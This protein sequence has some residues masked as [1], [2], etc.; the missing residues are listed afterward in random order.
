[1]QTTAVHH[2]T[3]ALL[4]NPVRDYAWGSRTAIPE[5]LGVA[6]TGVPAAE[7]W[8]G[9]HPGAPSRVCD[10]R[11][12]TL[13]AR[14]E[15]AP[16]A[17]LGADVVAR[18]G[19]RLP[20]LL[21]VIAAAAP[22]SLQ[23]HPNATQAAEGYAQENAR[24]MR[25]TAPDRNYRDPHHKPELLCALTP[26]DALCG[27]RPANDT[28]R[29]LDELLRVA[30]AAG[31]GTPAGRAVPALRPYV[32][33]LR[34]RPNQHGLREVVTGLLTLPMHKRAPLVGAVAVAAELA[35]ATSGEF[36]AELRTA[37]DLSGAYPGDVGV[38]IALLLNLLRLRPG[39][40]IF[41]PAGRMHA[42]LRGTGVEIMA[43]SDNV[44]RGGLT[45]KHVDVAELL[46]IL[47]LTDAP[48]PIPEPHRV[49]PVEEVY[50]TPAP[51][52][53][54]SRLQLDGSAPVTLAAAGPQI[55]LATEGE[56][57]VAG[58]GDPVHLARGRSAWVP[59]GVAI[60]LTGASTAFR[61]T[62]NLA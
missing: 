11:H 46:R 32:G 51:E 25:L 28:I 44:L 19:P 50:D 14:I 33:A 23:A 27:F 9:A 35:A 29:L 31:E 58:A 53:R 56:L 47:D 24:D 62:T 49:G 8:M 6:P 16:D 36:T 15:D 7:L 20:F 60:T 13:L 1:M 37:V 41:L 10:E 43:N 48:V 42:Y 39:Q 12:G 52:F 57:T 45:P 3:A 18:F 5:L 4:E 21:K 59:A 17:E 54:L 61:A 2:A 30:T 34:A 26:F 55:L 38:V 40:A 22:L